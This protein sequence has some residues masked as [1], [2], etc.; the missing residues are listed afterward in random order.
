MHDQHSAISNKMH[1]MQVNHAN[2]FDILRQAF[3]MAKERHQ[4]VMEEVEARILKMAENFN[5]DI[6]ITGVC[7]CACGWVW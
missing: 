1:R 3:S 7:V 6:I 2:R 5:A 4:V